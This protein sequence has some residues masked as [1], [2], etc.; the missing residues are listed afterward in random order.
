MQNI[1][2]KIFLCFVF[3]GESFAMLFSAW[4]S[5]Q[6]LAHYLPSQLMNSMKIQEKISSL[7]ASTSINI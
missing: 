5:L 4:Q 3:K 1:S 2:L 7:L 6:L